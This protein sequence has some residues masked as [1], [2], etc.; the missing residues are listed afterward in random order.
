M[1]LRQPEGLGGGTL[2][3]TREKTER[4]RDQPCGCRT[5]I[6]APEY[7]THRKKELQELWQYR[8]AR[9]SARPRSLGLCLPLRACRTVIIAARHG[10]RGGPRLHAMPPSPWAEEG[11]GSLR[12]PVGTCRAK[13]KNFM[14]NPVSRVGDRA[15]FARSLLS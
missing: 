15:D 6:A 12:M 3:R 13:E 11:Y 10:G 8:R 4:G 1:E 2:A 9:I 14:Q 7:K 5:Q